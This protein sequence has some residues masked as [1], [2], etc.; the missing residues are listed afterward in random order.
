MREPELNEN[1]HMCKKL[2]HFPWNPLKMSLDLGIFTLSLL[3]IFHSFLIFTLKPQL[4]SLQNGDNTST[5]RGMVN[6]K[7]APE[8]TLY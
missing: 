3:L 7:Y 4:Y 8:F 1:A 5:S 6:S 2:R